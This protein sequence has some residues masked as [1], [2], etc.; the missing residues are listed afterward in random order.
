VTSLKQTQILLRYGGNLA[1][2]ARP[3]TMTSTI[4]LAELRAHTD[5]ILDTVEISN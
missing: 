5:E 1:K 2:R 4:S 3:F